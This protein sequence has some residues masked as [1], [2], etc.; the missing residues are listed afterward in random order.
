M[1]RIAAFTVCMIISFQAFAHD[2]YYRERHYPS[3]MTGSHELDYFLRLMM[4]AAIDE[5]DDDLEDKIEKC[6]RYS[7]KYLDCDD[8]KECRKY[9][10]KLAKCGFPVPVDHYYDYDK[11]YKKKLRKCAKYS[12][13]YEYCN[14]YKKCKKYR[15]KLEDCGIAFPR[16]WREND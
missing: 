4:H 14:S 13:K 5:I 1:F 3:S 10:K 16:Y 2:N 12:Q 8:S 11:D 9:S 7:E 15:K 6:H